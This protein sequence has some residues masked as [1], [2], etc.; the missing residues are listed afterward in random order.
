MDPLYPW[1]SR[2]FGPS[3]SP[4]EVMD[5]GS[6][7]APRERRDGDNQELVRRRSSQM[8]TLS[9]RESGARAQH[10]DHEIRIKSGAKQN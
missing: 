9:R 10:P 2:D 3:M 1:S 6:Y 4:R 5:Q 8:S 7:L